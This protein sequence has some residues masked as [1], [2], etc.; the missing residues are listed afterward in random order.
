MTAI[1]R[2]DIPLQNHA[3][4]VEMRER[5]FK[6]HMA[7]LHKQPSWFS[8][9][10]ATGVGRM[11]LR[12][13]ADPDAGAL[14]TWEACVEAMQLGSALFVS[15]QEETGT[16]EYRVGH[17][18][19]TWRYGALPRAWAG[20]WV[21]AF[22][23]ACICREKK[24]MWEL[25]QVP[26]DLM[27]RAASVSQAVYDEYIYDWVAALQAFRLDRPEFGDHLVA[28]VE[29]TDPDRLRHAPRDNVLMINY[30]PMNLLSR[31]AQGDEPGFDTELAKALAWHKE[32][33][34]RDEDRSLDAEGF[35]ALGPLAVA[36][37]ARDA[38]FT[39]TVESEY[40]PKHLLDGEWVNEFPTR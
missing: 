12:C 31:L 35:V 17:E 30:P 27:R 36:C 1:S 5:R 22:W 14:E 18:V 38:G 33:W 20:N 11:N 15:A 39:L 16:F 7:S 28:A 13:A 29:G 26:V 9:A 3:D 2:H 25:A 4:V 19:R 21:T 6:R 24:R 8:N 32:Y 37:L 34:T 40:L 23:L 10:L